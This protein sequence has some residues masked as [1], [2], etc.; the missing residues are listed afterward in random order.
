ML[1]DRLDR[2]PAVA[3]VVVLKLFDVRRI[4]GLAYNF[5]DNECVDGFLLPKLL[6]REVVQARDRCPIRER[7]GV[8]EAC[9]DDRRRCE[10]VDGDVRVARDRAILGVIEH[11]CEVAMTSAPARCFDGCREFCDLLPEM[12]DGGGRWLA[13]DCREVV[14]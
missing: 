8:R 11:E 6:A 5:V 1:D 9:S 7:V 13:D 12:V 2:L 10:A 4:D 3:H 14:V